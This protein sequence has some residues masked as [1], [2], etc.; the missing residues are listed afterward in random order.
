MEDRHSMNS[1]QW[2]RGSGQFPF[3]K[4][5]LLENFLLGGEFPFKNTK[6]GAVSHPFWGN[7]WA[8]LKF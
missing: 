2:H 3:L 8:E 6:F 5:S 1:R 4:F 7:L